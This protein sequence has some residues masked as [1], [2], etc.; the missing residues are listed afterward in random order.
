MLAYDKILVDT[1]SCT[2]TYNGT[3]VTLRPKEYFLLKL[4]LKHPNRV[5]S[6]EEIIEQLWDIEHTPTFSSIR[7][8]IKG[9]RQAFKKANAA[10]KII[11]NVPGLGYRLSVLNKIESEDSKIICP[12]SIFK[13][14]IKSKAIEF[15]VIDEKLIIKSISQG[16]R[17]Y[18][19]YP[20]YLKIGIHALDAFPEFIGL[21]EN[22]NQVRDKKSEIFK[23]N[24]I[25]RNSNPD[26]P[27]FINF[28]VIADDS[29]SQFQQRETLLFVFFEDASEQML[30]KQRFVQRE[31]DT[32]LLLGSVYKLLEGKAFA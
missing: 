19:D 32:F 3:I 13:R 18:C 10:K 7:S 27:E 31:N 24:G 5:L 22:F 15:L 23:I 30:D 2:V 9:L 28:H 14:I 4:F 8:H 1:D 16:L 6:Y 25:A 11:E 17:N 20:D 29:K 26:R 12:S 21:E